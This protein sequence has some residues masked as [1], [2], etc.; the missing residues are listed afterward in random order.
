[1]PAR[2]RETLAGCAAGISFV[3]CAC[4][5]GEA[6][7]SAPADEAYG[8]GGSGGSGGAGGNGGTAESGGVGTGGAHEVGGSGGASGSV[9][10]RGSA[11]GSAGTASGGT[12]A[13]GGAPTKGSGGAAVMED[14]G[15]VATGG[16]SG[17]GAG[18]ATANQSLFS[19]DFEGTAK[20]WIS[21]PSDGWSVV[22]DG[23]KVFRQ[24]TLDNEFRV[25]SAGDAA[26]TDQ[27]VEARVKVL[28]FTG[29]STSY[30]AGVFVRFKDLDNHYFVALQSDGHVK[31]KK[32]SAGSS[33]SVSSQADATIAPGTWYTVKLAVKGSTLTAYLDGKEVLTATDADIPSGGFALGTKNATA[34]F[35]DV[36][37]TTP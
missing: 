5:T 11:G 3:I 17:G 34:E 12:P 23:T 30:L 29:S 24:G 8:S 28:A 14:G 33:T 31:I 21:V 26:W 18:A 2:Y 9:A 27:A 36:K 6:L 1:M 15:A 20:N 35:D 10:G 16:S 25:S 13:A 19:D 32:K 4:A 37:V 22:S 7:P